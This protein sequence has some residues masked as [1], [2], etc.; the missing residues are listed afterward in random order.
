MN[1]STG[2]ASLAV[3]QETHFGLLLPLW[4]A[5]ALPNLLQACRY[6]QQTISKRVMLASIPG[7]PWTTSQW[8]AGVQCEG[9]LRFLIV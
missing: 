7:W 1:P 3:L 5:I 9:F 2:Q 6:P 4:K 8:A